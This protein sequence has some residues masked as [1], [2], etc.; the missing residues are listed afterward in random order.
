VDELKARIKEL[1]LLNVIV[2][3]VEEGGIVYQGK[4][5]RVLDLRQL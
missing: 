1:T 5:R 2:E 3:P 4:A